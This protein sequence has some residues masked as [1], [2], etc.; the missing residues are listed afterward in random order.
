MNKSG[1]ESIGK[2]DGHSRTKECRDM[3]QSRY[4]RT[5]WHSLS[6]NHREKDSQG[7]QIIRV[8]KRPSPTEERRGKGKSG[9]EINLR[10]RGTLTSCR[11]KNGDKERILTSKV[12]HSLESAEG[13]I[14]TV[15]VSE[16][17]RDTHQLEST[18]EEKV[19]TWKE[20]K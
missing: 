16:Q 2:G 10:E 11:A 13:Q 14:R 20:S 7:R 19:R 5:E 15:K 4:R 3:D 8:S 1:Q 17:V 9:H 12:T 18:G 6:G